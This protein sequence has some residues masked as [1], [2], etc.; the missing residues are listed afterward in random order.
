MDMVR[1]DVFF[2]CFATSNHKNN[3]SNK[4]YLRFV[5]IVLCTRAG[6]KRDEDMM[7]EETCKLVLAYYY[8]E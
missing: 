4:K 8:Y 2:T 6:K 5:E 7:T 3:H 1:E